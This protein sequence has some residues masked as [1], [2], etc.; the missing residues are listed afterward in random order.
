MRPNSS[1]WQAPHIAALHDAAEFV[2]L[3]GAPYCGEFGVAEHPRAAFTVLRLD[4]ADDRVLLDQPHL[5]RPG[6]ERVDG[7]PGAG[8]S[9]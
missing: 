6:E 1:S 7:G 8:C 5:H 2:V 9:N 3:A 4:C